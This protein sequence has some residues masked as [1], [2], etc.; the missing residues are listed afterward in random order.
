VIE[1]AVAAGILMAVYVVGVV[2]VI[3][4][5]TRRRHPEDG[6]AV[7]CLV[8]V[9][10]GCAL[11]G[12]VLFLAARFQIRWLVYVIF[13]TTL[14]PA[15]YSIPQFVLA[16]W[17][18]LRARS[19]ARG[20]RLA[21]DELTNVLVGNT[22]VFHRS[23]LD[24]PREYDELKFYSTDGKLVCSEREN[25]ALKEL[26]RDANWSVKDDVLRTTGQFGPGTRNDFT[27]YQTPDGRIAYYIHEP[28]STLN[29]KLSGTATTLVT[30]KW[31]GET[32]PQPPTA[33]DSFH[34]R[35]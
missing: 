22:H 17:K 20:Q 10:A 5:P 24:P 31:E 35:D 23:V 13:A 28:F 6:M 11:L 4:W 12:C 30:G 33:E 18:K 3:V 34:R 1:V 9:A 25:G 27:L 2:L 7:G 14:Y 15:L 26:E 16:G 19:K 29:G 8:L 21:G 32:E